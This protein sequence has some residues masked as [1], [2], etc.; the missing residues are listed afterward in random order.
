M[1]SRKVEQ[2]QVEVGVESPDVRPI[3]IAQEV[4]FA[5][6]T[7]DPAVEHGLHPARKHLEAE[8]EIRSEGA[9]RGNG[10]KLPA[11][12]LRLAVRL[13]EQHDLAFGECR[14]RVV[15]P[16]VACGID[17]YTDGYAGGGL[18]AHL[19]RTREHEARRKYEKM[20]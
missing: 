3:D 5:Q 12:M 16:F 20:D 14:S 15:A 7:L 10:V 6:L 13:A 18:R 8:H 2:R 9:Q 1:H 4:G 11:M 19:G 17:P